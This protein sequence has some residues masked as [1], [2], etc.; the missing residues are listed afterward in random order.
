[1]P[2]KKRP[3][4]WAG[5]FAIHRRWPRSGRKKR[6]NLR[7]VEIEATSNPIRMQAVAPHHS[8]HRTAM[9]DQ[10]TADSPFEILKGPSYEW[11]THRDKAMQVVFMRR[12]GIITNNDTLE[13]RPI[14]Q[15]LP[16]GS[17]KHAM[18]FLD[19]NTDPWPPQVGLVDAE[20]TFE[21]WFN[22]D[23]APS[24][25]AQFD[26]AKDGKKAWRQARDFKKSFDEAREL[27]DQLSP[28]IKGKR[29]SA[30]I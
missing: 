28:S 14:V 6:R 25:Q 26:C 17:R 4:K 23:S 12:G 16:I 21:V 20:V 5:G 8:A 9:I 10:L 2:A 3:A 1:M 7:S 15:F 11:G 30:S 22:L 29:R 19:I 18:E 24:F 27:R 13:F